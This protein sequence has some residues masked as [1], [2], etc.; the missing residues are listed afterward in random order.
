MLQ[1]IIALILLLVGIYTGEANWFISSGLFEIAS[2]L[3]FWKE[4]KQ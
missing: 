4:N 1:G 3:S 2:V